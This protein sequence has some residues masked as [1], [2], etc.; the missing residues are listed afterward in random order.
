MESDLQ[1]VTSG[2]PTNQRMKRNHTHEKAEAKLKYWRRL[3]MLVR[4]LVVLTIGCVV[5][6]AGIFLLF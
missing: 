1:S 5:V 2:E 4:A 6:I 3:S